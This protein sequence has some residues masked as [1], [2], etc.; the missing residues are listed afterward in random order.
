MDCGKH[1]AERRDLVRNNTCTGAPDRKGHG[2]LQAVGNH[3]PLRRSHIRSDATFASGMG[4]EAAGRRVP[5]FER[6]AIP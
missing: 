5:G 4:L 6:N 1:Y 3:Q 2:A